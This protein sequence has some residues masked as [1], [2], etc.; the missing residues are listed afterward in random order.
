MPSEAVFGDSLLPPG[1]GPQEF[2][3]ITTTTAQVE[4]AVSERCQ[5]SVRPG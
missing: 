2:R 3:Q 1:C 5:I 4:E